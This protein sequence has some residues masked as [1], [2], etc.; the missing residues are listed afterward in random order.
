MG[1]TYDVAVGEDET[2]ELVMKDLI[3]EV[4]ATGDITF[5]ATGKITSSGRITVA[6]NGSAEA[7]KRFI[8]Y[9]S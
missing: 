5:S 2:V 8:E 3:A 7:I 4:D 6:L 1:T 9:Y